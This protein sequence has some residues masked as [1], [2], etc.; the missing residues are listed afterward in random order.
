MGGVN[1]WSFFFPS[2]LIEILCSELADDEFDI[3]DVISKDNHLNPTPYNI[4]EGDEETVSDDLESIPRASSGD[5]EETPRMG[6]YSEV[7]FYVQI[8]RNLIFF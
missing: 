6:S 8:M 4:R 2:W 1:I 7:C 3:G 5:L